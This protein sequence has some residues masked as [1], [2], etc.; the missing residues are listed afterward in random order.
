MK[1]L[2]ELLFEYS[3]RLSLE[4]LHFIP[5]DYRCYINY[6]GIDRIRANGYKELDIKNEMNSLLSTSDVRAKFIETFIIG[7]KYSLKESKLMISEIYQELNIIKTPK[8]T[9]LEEYFNIRKCI[10]IIDG[11]RINGYELLSLKE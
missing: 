6:L 2:C 11:K 1:A 10:M 9:D 8:A 4:N 5:M 7:S 3:G